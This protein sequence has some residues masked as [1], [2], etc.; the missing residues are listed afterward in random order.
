MDP[1]PPDRLE[2]LLTRAFDGEATP[3][4]RSELDRLTIVE[5][6]L[7]QLAELRDALRA[8]LTVPGPVDIA[9]EV[10]A[11]LAEDAEW[12]PTG[13]ALADAVRRPVDVAD[14]VMT[15]I[16]I[17]AIGL[18]PALR[19]TVSVPVDLADGVLAAIAA[20]A[21]FAPIGAEPTPAA[22]AD[23]AMLVSAPCQP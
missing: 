10:M 11:I 20:D 13:A 6:R 12:A 19:E 9:G 14:D 5:P 22:A 3:E 17:A 15:A 1:R 23:G 7:A 4:E 16:D 2:E 21:A 8:A 18:W